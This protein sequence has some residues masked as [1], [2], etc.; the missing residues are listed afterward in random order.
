MSLLLL[1][2]CVDD[3]REGKAGGRERLAWCTSQGCSHAPFS[4]ERLPFFHQIQGKIVVPTRPPRWRQKARMLRKSENVVHRLFDRQISKAAPNTHIHRARKLYENIV[5]N[6]TV[7][8]VECPDYCFRKFSNDGQYLICFSRDRQDLIVY[9][10]NWLTYCSKGENSEVEEE[11][12]LKA[13]KFESYFSLLYSVNLASGD[14]L[15]CKDFF[16]ATDCNVY[17]IFATATTP[18]SDAPTAPGAVPGVP[19][20]EK[21][22]L[23]LVR[24]ADGIIMDE[25]KFRDDFIHLA[26]NAGIFMYDDLVSVLS[27]RYQAIHILQVREAGMFVDVRTIGPFC[28]ED[29]EFVLNSHSQVES[30]FQSQCMGFHKAKGLSPD[31]PLE[32]LDVEARALSLKVNPQVQYAMGQYRSNDVLGELSSQGYGGS[33][34]G[35]GIVEGL[36]RPSR[37]SHCL[38]DA[39]AIGIFDTST[40]NASRELPSSGAPSEHS[41]GTSRRMFSDR[42]QTP[43]NS[44]PLD[45]LARDAAG[46]PGNHARMYDHFQSQ[47]GGQ[48]PS[49]ASTSGN[50]GS[51]GH[52]G[53]PFS[54]SVSYSSA[55][56]ES[57][58][59][60]R[61][62]Y[63][64][65]SSDTVGSS[66]YRDRSISGGSISYGDPGVRGR[67]QSEES[68][69]YVVS[70]RVSEDGSQR[71]SR[72]PEGSVSG[73]SL[74]PGVRDTSVQHP[75]SDT[76]IG[77]VR[78]RDSQGSSSTSYTSSEVRSAGASTARAAASGRGFNEVSTSVRS[79]PPNSSHRPSAP[80]RQDQQTASEEVGANLNSVQMLGGLKQRLLSFIFRTIGSQDVDPVVRAQRLKRFYYYHFQNYVDLVM[81]KVQFLDRYHLL[82]KFGSVDGVVSYNLDATHQTA[83]FV[84]YNIETTEILCFYQNSSEEFSQ[85]FEQYHDFFRVAPCYPL[86]MGFISSYSNNDSAREQLR[87]QKAAYSNNKSNSYSQV[88]RRTLASL[89]CN[90]Q[91]HSPSTY[92]DQSLFHFD[93]KLISATNRHKPCMEHPIKFLSRRKRNTLKFKINTGLEFGSGDGR[94]K[95]A[96]SFIFHPI[97]PFAISIQHSFMQPS[98]VN[99]HFRR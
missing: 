42:H 95:R 9:R 45:T 75:V 17:G 38:Y 37:E 84:V 76:G 28:R 24:L 96:A 3:E 89:P 26:H 16:L 83:F 35:G 15:I 12:P 20:M 92:F 48:R 81:W 49:P 94:V 33:R 98:I 13:K 72:Y 43:L 87:K 44:S 90:C 47:R 32:S 70:S 40:Q 64:N 54:Y 57:Q 71:H 19:S 51:R 53:P 73:N 4:I 8:D 7:Y 59:G 10:H 82:I 61:S 85:L 60:S 21:I 30:L 55:S 23:Y 93:E 18:V 5:P 80:A 62:I 63:L 27:V 69:E 50:G 88:V 68:V 25:R 78:S 79:G 74:L 41:Q 14:E 99:F 52:L 91:S 1:G 11:L 65:S 31:I 39:Q 56:S 22:T 46:V 67:Y 34:S 86:Y 97:F 77:R 66:R 58:R 36:L 6:F 29:D 2:E